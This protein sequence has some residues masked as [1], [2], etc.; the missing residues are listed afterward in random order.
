[1]SA[2]DSKNSSSPQWPQWPQWLPLREDLREHRPYGAPQI[3]VPVRLNTNENP[4]GPSR[5][6][7]KDLESA[8]NEIGLRLNRYP[9]RE[10]VEL[11]SA[12]ARYINQLSD[13]TLASSNIWAANGSNEIIQSLFLAF[14]GNNRKALGFEPSYS[15]HRNIARTTGTTWLEVPRNSEFMIDIERAQSEIQTLSP[16]MIFLTT[17]NN[18]TGTISSLAEIAALAKGARDVGALLV[19]D[20]A[21][22]EFSSELS[23]VTL[24]NQFPNIV[25]CRTMSKAFAFAGARVGYLVADSAVIDAMLLVRLPYHLS[26][27]TQALALVALSYSKE[28]LANVALLSKERERIAAELARIGVVVL[29][30][31]ANFFLFKTEKPEE[32]WAALLAR[33]VLIRDVALPEHLRV[34]VGTPE[35]NDRFITELKSALEQGSAHKRDQ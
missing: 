19:V 1:M 5:A 16:S 11:R 10:A 17:P 25:V 2:A 13:T 23:A 21:Y 34:T 6:L 7:V 26:S 20:E 22:Q 33:G 14:G 24:I 32:L 12:L 18:P 9:D 27:A 15:M 35:E 28:L 31:G 4:F 30:S 8:I 29:P 3:D